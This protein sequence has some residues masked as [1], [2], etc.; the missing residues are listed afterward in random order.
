MIFDGELRRGDN[1]HPECFAADTRGREA[2]LA[3]SIVN[4]PSVVRTYGACEWDELNDDGKQW[5][6]AIVRETLRRAATLGG[7]GG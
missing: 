7:D 3:E 4:C 1:Y 5:V 6:I 2:S